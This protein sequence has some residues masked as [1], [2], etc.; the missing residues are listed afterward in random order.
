MQIDTTKYKS[1]E[2][3]SYDYEINIGYYNNS[4]IILT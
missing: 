3:N 2:I 1:R 4:N